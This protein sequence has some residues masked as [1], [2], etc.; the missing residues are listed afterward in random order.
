MTTQTKAHPSMNE[1]LGAS[2]QDD[3]HEIRPPDYMRVGEEIIRPGAGDPSGMKVSDLRFKG[4]VRVWDTKTGIASLQPW[5]LMWQTMRKTHPDGSPF[6]TRT[7]PHIV[8][9][10][11]ADLFCPLNP[12][13]SEYEGLKGMGFKPCGKRHIP[14]LDGQDAHVRKSHKRAFVVIERLRQEKIRGEDRAL[15]LEALRTN[16][17]VLAALAGNV[18]PG[19]AVALPV[20]TLNCPKCGKAFTKGSQGGAKSAVRGHGRRCKA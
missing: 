12:A 15:Q 13:A 9:N 7:D 2:S 20:F 10:H 11:G 1:F 14:H 16:Q 3:G 8:P 6:F 5:Y 4:Y 19:A 17:S 18:E